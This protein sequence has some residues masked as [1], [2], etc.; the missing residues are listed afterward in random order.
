[1]AKVLIIDDDPLLLTMYEQK[2]RRD[3]YE[4]ATALTGGEGLAKIREENPTVVLLDIMMPKISGL[5]VLEAMKK[6]PKIRDIPV[7][8]LTNLARGE[9]DIE[10]GLELGAI[11]YLVKN[12]TRPSQVVAKVKE[13]LAATSRD[14]LPKVKG[15]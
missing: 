14:E 3:G 1:M 11:A 15:V 13:L 8:L 5:E 9:E 2:F 7:I 6:D 4:V 12:Q 10:R